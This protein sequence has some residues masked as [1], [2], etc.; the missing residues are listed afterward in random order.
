MGDEVATDAAA[1][2]PSLGET[3]KAARE[4]K[5][6]SVEKAAAD[7]HLR[8]ELIEKLEAD[9]LAELGAPVFVKGYLRQYA[10]LLGLETDRVTE[11]YA[12][13]GGPEESPVVGKKPVKLRDDQQVAIWGAAA[14]IAVL[15]GLATL[16]W[17]QTGPAPEPEVA[18]PEAVETLEPVAL[19]P[20][21]QVTEAPEPDVEEPATAAAEEEAE[22]V[23][24][25]ATPG[26]KVFQVEMSFSADSWAE[27][28][29]P[30]GQRLF[31]GLGRAGAR[32]RFAAQGPISFLLGNADGVALAVDGQPYP[33]PSEGRQGNL[34]RFV[35]LAED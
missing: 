24:E 20:E 30:N 28:T 32:S 12:R 6:L 26:P 5:N 13:A 10:L 33:I 22:P 3:L 9:Q 8:P 29:D 21:E 15:G 23:S 7:L 14:L 34:A 25:A 31:Y 2:G 18:L 19:A 11:L 16:I 4:A 1:A 35:V 17:W 27:V